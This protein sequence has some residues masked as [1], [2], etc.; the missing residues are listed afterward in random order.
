MKYVARLPRFLWRN[1]KGLVQDAARSMA[2]TLATAAIGVQALTQMSI[3]SLGIAASATEAT[4]IGA[5]EIGGFEAAACGTVAIEEGALV[6]GGACLG[7]LGLVA[8]MAAAGLLFLG[9]MIETKA[10]EK[11]NI[12][13]ATD[14]HFELLEEWV[15]N[16]FKHQDLKA[17]SQDCVMALEDA[18][19]AAMS[20]T[21]E[22]LEFDGFQSAAQQISKISTLRN[23]E[24][25]AR[26]AGPAHRSEFVDFQ[27]VGFAAMLNFHNNLLTTMTMELSMRNFSDGVLKLETET[28]IAEE[29]IRVMDVYFEVFNYTGNTYEGALGGQVF[30]Q[31]K[32]TCSDKKFTF[33]KNSSFTYLNGRDCTVLDDLVKNYTDLIQEIP[34]LR[35]RI[36][37][38]V[39][40]HSLVKSSP[41]YIPMGQGDLGHHWIV[42]LTGGPNGGRPTYVTCKDLGNHTLF[43]RKSVCES[44]PGCQWGDKGSCEETPHSNDLGDDPCAW[45][46]GDKWN[47]PAICYNYKMHLKDRDGNKVYCVWNS[48]SSGKFGINQGCVRANLFPNYQANNN[49]PFPR[50]ACRKTDKSVNYTIPAVTTA[51]IGLPNQTIFS[52]QDTPLQPFFNA[53]SGE[54]TDFPAQAC[55]Y[56]RTGVDIGKPC[57]CEQLEPVETLRPDILGNYRCLK[58]KNNCYF[59]TG[60]APS[61]ETDRYH[62]YQMLDATGRVCVDPETFAGYYH[63]HW[64]PGNT[65]GPPVYRN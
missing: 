60:W 19:Q 42:D 57:V 63:P 2:F 11:A 21:C 18:Q 61:F 64:T 13:R 24:Y 28:K 22:G 40:E 7:P 53:T 26:S 17:M 50:F 65:L 39:W 14:A 8:G 3:T 32:G 43:N 34:L 38:G 52:Q 4:A 56:I 20:V 48:D 23:C 35:Y 54:C 46:G 47:N 36:P 44:I 30:N 15:L 33:N 59:Q 58:S 41:Y 16:A 31:M 6:A 10:I 51:D 27:V 55:R 37:L 5:L 9:G 62:T 25:N 49:R 1:L 12:K 29:F 45:T